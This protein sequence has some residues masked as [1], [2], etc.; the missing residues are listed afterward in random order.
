M[1][2]VFLPFAVA[3]VCTYF[4]LI[5]QFN[6]LAIGAAIGWIALWASVKAHPPLD[7]VEG[8]PALV[9]L[10]LGCIVMAAV[11]PL[12][13]LGRKITKSRDQS[14]NF[15]VTSSNFHFPKLFSNSEDGDEFGEKRASKSREEA[16]HDY[17]MR[18]RGALRNDGG[19]RGKR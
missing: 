11:V 12:I 1:T 17:K 2:S 3:A 19:G 16:L 8:E 4:A 15:S 5:R 13:S 10:Q 18:V 14:G 9:I 7:M 6:L